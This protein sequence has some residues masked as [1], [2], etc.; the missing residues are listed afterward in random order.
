MSAQIFS[1]IPTYTSNHFWLSYQTTA[2]NTHIEMQMKSKIWSTAN[3]PQTLNFLQ[4][5]FPQVL[6]TRCFN[7]QNLPFT[8]EVKNTEIGHLFEHILLQQLYLLKSS[9]GFTNVT[10]NGRTFWNWNKHPYGH[11]QIVVDC[12]KQDAQFLMPALEYTVSLTETLLS[13]Q[14]LEN[15]RVAAEGLPVSANVAVI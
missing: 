11:F 1:L 2:N 14:A 15:T 3:L 12:G 4:D 7:D 13:T 8:E 6:K 5:N 9:A 10:F